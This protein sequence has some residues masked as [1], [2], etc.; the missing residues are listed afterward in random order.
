MCLRERG[1]G[2]IKE[3]E[4]E[5]E[6][7]RAQWRKIEGIFAKALVPYPGT[8]SSY[9]I[10]PLY[11]VVKVTLQGCSLVGGLYGAEKRQS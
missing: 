6:R 8:T 1:R 10:G 11:H 2:W 5:R 7:L 4:R 3:R 9:A